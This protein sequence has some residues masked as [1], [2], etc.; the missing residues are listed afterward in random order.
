MAVEAG[1]AA[2]EVAA[3]DAKH[4]YFSLNLNRCFQ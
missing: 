1:M 4:L 2:A 3:I